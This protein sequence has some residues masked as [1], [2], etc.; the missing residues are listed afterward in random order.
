MNWPGLDA[1]SLALP[2]PWP[3]VIACAL[4]VFAAYLVFGMSGFGASLITIPV[5]SQLLP[6]PLL[7]SLAVVTDLAAAIVMAVA[8]RAA[9]GGVPG[10]PGVDVRMQQGAD[11][12]ELWRLAPAAVVGAIVGVTLLVGLPR[13]ATLL[14]LGVF[15]LGYGLWAWRAR[16]AQTPL[17]A[18]WGAGF[19]FVGGLLGALFGIGGPPY[20]I[21]L[22]RRILDRDRLRA[23][24]SAIVLLSL[25]IR[26]LVFLAAGLLLQ[27][28]LLPMLVLLV[29]V[30]IISV[31]V[32]N[33]L[34]RQ[35]SRERL[36]RVISVLLASSGAV[37]I[38]RACLSLS[39]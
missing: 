20:V 26:F 21:Y 25:L 35:V 13:A 4:T 37:L 18:R 38:V 29:P 22:S 19:G 16:P 24:I 12:A 3:L 36:L 8:T 14:V 23:T 27:P 2:L 33:R 11:R 39:A 1:L 7:L 10:P 34:V 9:P 31:L 6:L 30:C 32:G 15:L 28:G 17:A 5:L